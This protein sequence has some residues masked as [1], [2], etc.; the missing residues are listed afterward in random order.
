MNTT[1]YR[2]FSGETLLYV[3]I[4]LSAL[5]RISQHKRY[6]KWFSKHPP[7]HMTMEHFDSRVDAEGAERE[8]IKEERPVYNDVYNGTTKR[9][10]AAVKDLSE[11]ITKA[12]VKK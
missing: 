3:G 1:L 4:S 6:S 10:K 9:K 8:A 12:E 7:T 5:N 11:I 2:V